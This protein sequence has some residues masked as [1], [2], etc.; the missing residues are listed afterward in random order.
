MAV[1]RLL[2]SPSESLLTDH[3][4]S[5]ESRSE[6]DGRNASCVCFPSPSLTVDEMRGIASFAAALD[7]PAQCKG[8]RSQKCCSSP[9]DRS[10]VS[11]A[12]S[13]SR[14][15]GVSRPPSSAAYCAAAKIPV[16]KRS[17]R[18]SISCSAEDVAPL[19]PACEAVS[20]IRCSSA[21]RA[22]SESASWGVD[23]GISDRMT[24]FC[25]GR[26]TGFAL[27]AALV[28]CSGWTASC[29]SGGAGFAS[30]PKIAAEDEETAQL[31]T[32]PDMI[33]SMGRRSIHILE[34][35]SKL[36]SASTSI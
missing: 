31:G 36:L 16:M 34:G 32:L 14:A 29:F 33:W 35:I 13:K 4:S 8:C 10:C 3:N 11:R 15:D 30:S 24:D 18:C 12:Y 6:S 21:A 1:R 28:T 26:G 22:P 7:E 9:T 19:K 17:V 2:N 25:R 20:A 27:A 5:S 23:G